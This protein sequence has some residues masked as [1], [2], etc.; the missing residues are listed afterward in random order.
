ME[1]L[2]LLYT[3]NEILA[4]KRSSVVGVRDKIPVFCKN[5]FVF[6]FIK[7]KPASCNLFAKI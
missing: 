1:K 5:D 6:S 2:F 7:N 4:K 3:K